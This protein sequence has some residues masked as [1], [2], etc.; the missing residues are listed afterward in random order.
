MKEIVPKMVGEFRYPNVMAAPKIEKVVVNIGVGRLRDEKV[1][2]SIR[3]SLALITG[4]KLAPRRAKVAIAAFKT[5]KGLVIGYTAT[6][7]GKRMYDFLDR[8]I[9]VALP[10]QRD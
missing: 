2:D 9:H 7:R 8:L 6:L 4:Q 5:R 10:R 3:Q 1:Q